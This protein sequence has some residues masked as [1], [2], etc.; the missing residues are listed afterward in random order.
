MKSTLY[1]ITFLPFFLFSQNEFKGMVM[2]LNAQNQHQPLFGANV[3]W[4]NTSIGTI[5]SED[6]TFIVPYEPSYKKLVISYIGFQT[7]IP[8]YSLAQLVHR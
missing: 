7:G 2:E 1:I 6:G 3:F 4:L 5:T 8:N